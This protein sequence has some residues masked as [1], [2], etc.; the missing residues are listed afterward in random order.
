MKWSRS[1]VAYTAALLALTGLS[2]VAKAINQFRFF[3][4]PDSYYYLLIARNLLDH[5]HPTGTL[6]AG[7]MPFPPAGY[8]AMKSTFPMAVA[9]VMAFRLPAEQA[10]HL[11]AA[12][13]AVLAVPVAFWAVWRLLDSRGAGLTAAALIAT[14]Y[15]IT[16]WSGFVMSDSLSVLL[17][18]AVLGLVAK[19]RPDELS[20]A[21]DIGTG[22]IA[23]LLLLSRPT[24][25]VA[26]PLLLW[27]GFSAFGWTW[28]RVATAV[29]ACVL[30]VAVISAFWFPPPAYTMRILVRLLPVIGAAAVVAVVA[31]LVM[32]GRRAH[33]ATAGGDARDGAGRGT[34]VSAAM[35]RVGRVAY[36]LLAVVPLLIYLLQ[37]AA[38]RI[39][40][41]QS[42]FL[43]LHRF[44]ARDWVSVVFLVVGAYALDRAHR[45]D[46]GGALLASI[47]VLLGVY[48][49][50]EPRDSRYL[51]HLLPFMV[52][53]VGAT[54]LLPKLAANAGRIALAALIVSVGVLGVRGLSR[55]E[56]DFLT[57]DYP[58]EVAAGLAP[59]LGAGGTLITGLPWAYHF[60]TDLPAWSAAT[61]SV[62]QFASYVPDDAKVLLLADASLHVG[63]PELSSAVA[64]TFADRQ[65]LSF[66][67]PV[68]FLYGYSSLADT[69]PVRLYELTAAEMRSLVAS[70]SPA[71]EGSDTP[72]PVR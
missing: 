19:E 67:V 39:G 22:V 5:G 41:G 53:V 14:S 4:F 7:G 34:A 62:L 38:T 11:V 12:A 1:T 54:A 42:P 27:M 65:V 61:D 25:F 37:L 13:G 20:N 32:R 17:A 64:S 2:A 31:V 70:Y 35:E 59:A 3:I 36:Y 47:V 8:A 15:G 52:P 68:E 71:D 46:V 40:G 44:V 57:T 18:L 49:W 72:G 29:V 56:A 50:V 9:A 24:Y 16:Y 23:A 55:A 66:S 51:V 21:G 58:R 26:L 30:P 60:R 28:K 6:G 10:G 43:A 48:Y 33:G 69:E 63:H 45:R